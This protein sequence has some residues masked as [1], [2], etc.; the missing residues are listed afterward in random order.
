VVGAADGDG[1][2]SEGVGAGMTVGGW[3]YWRNAKKLTP[4]QNQTT[5]GRCLYVT[6]MLS[7][8]TLGSVNNSSNL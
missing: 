6:Y 3:G 4:H 2:G 7:L 8:V 5:L 1:V